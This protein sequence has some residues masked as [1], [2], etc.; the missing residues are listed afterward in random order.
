MKE[1]DR[2]E[3]DDEEPS[4]WEASPDLRRDAEPH[5]SRL[6]YT[7]ALVA[8]F[9]WAIG[10]LLLFP[11]LLAKAGALFLGGASLRRVQSAS[12]RHQRPRAADP[13]ALS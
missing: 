13:P 1:V 12:T 9:L 10:W 3:R 6:L 5:R 2:P 7:L 8:L 4:P 11:V